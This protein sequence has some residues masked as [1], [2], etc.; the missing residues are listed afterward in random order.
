MY[1]YIYIFIIALFALNVNAANNAPVSWSVKFTETDNN[2]AELLF[3]ADI[4]DG[5]EV[6][7]LQLP[8]GGPRSTRVVIEECAGIKVN[9]PLYEITPYQENYDTLFELILKSYRKK[10]T[11]ALPVEI[12]SHPIN[13]SGYI[14]YQASNRKTC[15]PP[16]RHRFNINIPGKADI[17]AVPAYQ[18]AASNEGTERVTASPEEVIRWN[19]AKDIIQQIG[20]AE[21]PKAVNG[22]DLLNRGFSNGL[23]ALCFP[24]LWTIILMT[25]YSFRKV[26]TSRKLLLL[27]ILSY[28]LTLVILFP[29]CG[30]LITQLF[31]YSFF[32]EIN[33]NAYF[34][35]AMFLIFLALTA[36]LFGVK[37]MKLPEKSP[38]SVRL[39]LLGATVLILVLSS[40]GRFIGQIL[41]ES[42]SFEPITG[43]LI[44]FFG[45]ICAFITVT[46]A[47]C[48]ICNWNTATLESK[49][50]LTTL[51]R[52]VGFF[53]LS[54]SITFLSDINLSYGYNV[55]GRD[56]FIA[57]WISIYAILGVYLLGGFSFLRDRDNS[58][59]KITVKRLV[60]AITAFG[61]CLYMVPGLWGAPL[62]IINLMI[63]PSYTQEFSLYDNY[64]DNLFNDYDEG[65]S[66][67]YTH[68]RPVLLTFSSVGD[69]ESRM[70]ESML[71]NFTPVRT[72][73][74][75]EFAI[76]ALKTDSKEELPKSRLVSI[77]GKTTRITTYGELWSALQQER[78][79][80]TAKPYQIILSPYGE[81][82]SGALGYSDSVK[83]YLEFL[84]KALNRYKKQYDKTEQG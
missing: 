16:T 84:L 58:T 27:K 62:S 56:V 76:I 1:R 78:F 38:A 5:W 69:A 82:L 2:K 39:L 25:I 68:E 32:S 54:Y 41:K 49:A 73:L 51:N 7:G 57:V 46:T 75:N 22:L 8:E 67:A 35:I 23:L 64:K 50:R 20:E 29:F 40:T 28:D 80:S 31:G 79:G 10:A 47:I 70:M 61:F 11:L 4:S 37:G 44:L 53:I 19:S 42:A 18:A 71:W 26:R 77:D 12:V 14:I 63:P 33:G 72:I 48:L 55:M 15:T 9:G 45:F 34:N 13:I 3:S 30:L 65:M 60:A 21:Q 83:E 81:P 17:A 6:Y 36:Y 52:I 43:P 24:S 66:Y 74:N 59:P